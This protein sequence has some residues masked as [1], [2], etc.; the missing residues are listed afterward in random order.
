MSENKRLRGAYA[1]RNMQDTTTKKGATKAPF[2]YWL[3]Q[4]LISQQ[5]LVS[6]SNL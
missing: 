2:F 6:A 1:P 3:I 4:V 5:V